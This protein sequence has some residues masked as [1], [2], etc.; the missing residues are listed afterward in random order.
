MEYFYIEGLEQKGPFSLDQLISRGIKSDTLIWKKG[1]NE[2]KPARDVEEL[3]SIFQEIPPPLP[4]AVGNCQEEEEEAFIE[5]SD[6]KLWITIKVFSA[7]LVLLGLAL[8][9]SQQIVEVKRKR[10]R[11]EIQSELDE[12]FEG[13]PE[14]LDGIFDPNIGGTTV[15]LE[16]NFDNSYSS[17]KKWGEANNAT[18]VF[19]NLYCGF[20]VE[21]LTKNGNRYIKT[22]YEPM[23]LGYRTP[24]KEY[25]TFNG[26][27]YYIEKP[28]KTVKECYQEMFDI[29]TNEN[30]K[31]P[32]A[33]SPGKYLVIKD[34]TRIRNDYFRVGSDYSNDGGV[35]Y[36]SETYM[37]SDWVM[38]YRFTE[39]TWAVEEDKVF[40]MAKEDL[41]L[42]WLIF[43][44]I[45]MLAVLVLLLVNPRYF[46]NLHLYGKRW[47]YVSAP[48]QELFFKHSFVKPNFFLEK[49]ND[50]SSIG[51]VRFI[52][53]GHVVKLS[54][55]NRVLF[56][57]IENLDKN[58]LQLVAVK[59]NEKLIFKRR[60]F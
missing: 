52:K 57:R 19:N 2:W 4:K 7:V 44:G 9:V 58:N 21:K 60:N 30:Q 10:L 40:G 8:L 20:I 56:Y 14:V 3:K 31:S 46:K 33:Y 50:N 16:T 26:G 36:G 6:A 22:T 48:E 35:R 18:V 1:L 42:Y 37:N 13:R 32:N 38:E 39:A 51:V 15:E 12:I 43:A 11:Q 49:K 5:S 17:I 28:K 53:R 54:Y 47:F 59:D 55:A 25:M 24:L 34:I 45:I 41:Y 23:W 29:L 27:W